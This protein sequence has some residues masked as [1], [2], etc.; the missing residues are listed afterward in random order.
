MTIAFLESPRFPDELAAWATGGRGFN[1][2]VVQTYG[3]DEYRNAA[4]TQR[5]GRW[6]IAN[7]L[8][9]A[10]PAIATYNAA[11]LVDFLNVVLGR[12]GAFRFQDPRDHTDGGAGVFVMITATTFQ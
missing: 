8:R 6:D 2:T 11:V 1:T 12:L 5:L 4:W 10:N 7:A 9:V 3:G